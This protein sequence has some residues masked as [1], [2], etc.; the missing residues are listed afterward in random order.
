MVYHYIINKKGEYNKMTV[1]LSAGF[2]ALMVMVSCAIGDNPLST[3]KA[4]TKEEAEENFKYNFCK[5]LY[6]FVLVF[7]GFSIIAILTTLF[8]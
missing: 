8:I 4:T 1:L 7:G 3:P 5:L 2:I 6:S